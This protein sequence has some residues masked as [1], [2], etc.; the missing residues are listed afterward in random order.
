MYKEYLKA[1]G[2]ISE[3]EFNEVIKS[4]PEFEINCDEVNFNECLQDKTDLAFDLIN[5]IISSKWKSVYVDDCNFE[6]RTINLYNVESSKDL[7]EIKEFFSNWTID[8][9]EEYL[10]E[11]EDSEKEDMLNDECRKLRELISDKVYN[12][13][14]I[15]K[16]KYILEYVDKA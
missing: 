13:N 2:V 12:L 6:N 8:G 15:D 14:D 3:E 7:K 16:L 5:Y 4:L 9:Y 10:K 11:L 1:L